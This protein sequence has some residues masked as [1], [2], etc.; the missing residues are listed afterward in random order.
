MWT[1]SG[2]YGQRDL[3]NRWSSRQA[4]FERNLTSALYLARIGFVAGPWSSFV[5]GLNLTL[6]VCQ[7][8]MR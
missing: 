2:A 4:T 8:L 7:A 3:I 6:L 5:P 1:L